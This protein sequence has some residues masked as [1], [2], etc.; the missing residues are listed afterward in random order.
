MFILYIILCLWLI[1]ISNSLGYIRNELT[2][3]ETSVKN[4][5]LK[6]LRFSHAKITDYYDS[7][8]GGGPKA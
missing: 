1:S 3:L 4:N 5:N 6:T 8:I 2:H 7:I